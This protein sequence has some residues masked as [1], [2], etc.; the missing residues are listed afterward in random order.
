MIESRHRIY[1]INTIILLYITF[2]F[3]L[4]V[5]ITGEGSYRVSSISV[6]S[7]SRL[8]GTSISQ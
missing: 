5:A 4:K 6:L 1:I 7:V 2:L 3:N 8:S